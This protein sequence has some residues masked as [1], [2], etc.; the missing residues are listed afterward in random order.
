MGAGSVGTVPAALLSMTPLI[1]AAGEA[2]TGSTGR[3]A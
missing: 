1:D 2:G 3:A